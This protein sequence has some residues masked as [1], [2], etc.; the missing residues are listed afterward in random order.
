[1]KELCKIYLVNVCYHEPQG[2]LYLTSVN[3]LPRVKSVNIAISETVKNRPR[4]KK[5]KYPL[6]TA[7]WIIANHPNHHHHNYHRHHR[8]HH[9]HDNDDRDDDDDAADDDDDENDDDESDG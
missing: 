1:M 3:N 9:Q 2:I 8:H 5:C 7:S 4:S 6:I